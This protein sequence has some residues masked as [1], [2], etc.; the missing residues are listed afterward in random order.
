MTTKE[1]AAAAALEYVKDGMTVGLGSGSTSE[2][3]IRAL[4]AAI[5][6]GR[7]G[8]LRCIPT[9]VQSQRL[10]EQLG[11]PLVP[12]TMSGQ[13][14]LAVDGADEVDP[15]LNLIKGLGGAMLREKITEQNARRFIVI[16][17]QSKLVPQLGSRG[18]VPV[19]ILPFASEAQ[20]D[21]IRKMGGRPAQRMTGDGKPYITDNG[22]LCYDCFFGPIADPAGLDATLAARAGVVETGL[23]IAMVE[24]VIVAY[25]DRVEE[26]VARGRR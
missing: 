18:P 9:S 15:E 19:E 20:V 21:Y 3:F 10:A 2:C 12:L 16:V 8:N 11:I 6:A 13:I 25:E 1:R 7:F 22:N 5:A 4:G 23:F 24:R 14:D 17:D 26:L